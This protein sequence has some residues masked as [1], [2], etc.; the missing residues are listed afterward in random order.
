[1]NLEGHSA[2]HFTTG[3]YQVG[4]QIS[5]NFLFINVFPS[6]DSHYRQSQI[7]PI[8]TL[9]DQLPKHLL[10]IYENIW[11]DKLNATINI[12]KMLL[13][14]IKFVLWQI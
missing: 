3:F 5:G 7:L 8:V 13:P 12:N 2:A 4:D 6:I 1:M 9:V 14:S 11:L 10:S